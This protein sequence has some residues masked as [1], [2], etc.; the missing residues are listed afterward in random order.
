MNVQLQGNEQ[1]TKLFNDWYVAMLKQDVSQATSLRHEAKELT[2]VLKNKSISQLQTQDLLLYYSLLDFKYKVLTDDTNISANEFEAI[3]CHYREGLD[4]KLAFHYYSCKAMHN[5]LL[6]NYI[7]A[8][9]CFNSAEQ[10]LQYIHNEFEQA[11]FYYEFGVLCYHIQQPLLTIKHVLK[12]KEIYIRHSSYVINQI[13]CDVTLGLASITLNQFEQAEEY[14]IKCLELASKHK[15]D[16]LATL[17]RYNLGFLYAKQNLSDTAI[18][19]LTE[20]YQEEK[21]FHKTLFLLAQEHFK[22][23]Q[24]KEANVYW[25][26]G[27]KLADIEYTHHYRI[28]QAIY[29]VNHRESLETTITNG[30]K[31]FEEQQLYGFIEEYVGYLAKH[32]YNSGDATKASKYFNISYDAKQILTKRSSLK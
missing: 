1:V 11:E 30:V 28:I 16:R 24:I 31:Y 23:S 18:R 2:N 25:E 19:Y 26:E 10:L 27:I 3:E 9:E 32:F 15:N 29:D 12:A 8:G 14:F 21:P 5:T 7:E 17:I 4:N 6:G 20:V 22:L 13:E